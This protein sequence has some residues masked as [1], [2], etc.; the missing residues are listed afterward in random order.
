[1][2]LN[3]MYTYYLILGVD[4]ILGMTYLGLLFQ[5]LQEAIIKVLVWSEVLSKGTTGEEFISRLMR[6][7]AEFILQGLLD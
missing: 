1:M 2:W 4:Q 6:S 3:A 7:L 5:S